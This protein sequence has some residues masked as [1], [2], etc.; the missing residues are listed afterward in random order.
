MLKCD[1]LKDEVLDKKVKFEY[2]YGNIE[3]KIE[4]LNALKSVLRKR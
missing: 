1:A 3:H 4:A 2:L